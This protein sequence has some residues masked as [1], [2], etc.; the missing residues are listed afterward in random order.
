MS[1]AKR[2]PCVGICSTTYGDLVCRGCKRFAHEIV[3][4]NG[5]EPEQREQI[6]QRLND[7]RDQVVAQFLY[8]ADA[9]S[10][11]QYC[12]VTGVEN[13]KSAGNIYQLLSH[14]VTGNGALQDA[15]RQSRVAEQ[16]ALEGM[17]AIDSEVYARSQAH[18]ERNFRITS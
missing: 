8:V 1:R 6:W 5:Y 12:R 16:D 3:A 14:L 2:T 10:L 9:Q 17:K 4:W 18:Y 15:G 11:E 13:S 7:L